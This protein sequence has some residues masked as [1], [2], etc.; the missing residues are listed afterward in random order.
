MY[1][2]D[3]FHAVMTKLMHPCF[4]AEIHSKL[5]MGS[6]ITENPAVANDLRV[7]CRYTEVTFYYGDSANEKRQEMLMASMTP[8]KDCEYDFNIDEIMGHFLKVS[9]LPEMSNLSHT[10]RKADISYALGA[11]IDEI[12]TIAGRTSKTVQTVLHEDQ[13]LVFL[14]HPSTTVFEVIAFN[15]NK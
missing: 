13:I 12:V 1:V 11:I 8:N 4:K 7:N 6:R 9:D 15:L 10:L 2:T 14:K 5:E 3:S